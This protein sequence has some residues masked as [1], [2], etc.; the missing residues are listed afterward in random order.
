[1]TLTTVRSTGANHLN[2]ENA[3]FHDDHLEPA[4]RHL[5]EAG[6]E[7]TRKRNEAE[8]AGLSDDS[9]QLSRQLTLVL[10]ATEALQLAL[11]LTPELLL[12]R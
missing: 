4:M 6:S 5:L 8:A 2:K 3:M 7:I 9:D 12:R 11:G 10:D 1:M